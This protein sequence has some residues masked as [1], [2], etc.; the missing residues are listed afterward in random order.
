MRLNE[1]DEH[2]LHTSMQGSSSRNVAKATESALPNR[3]RDRAKWRRFVN[4]SFF[5][6]FENVFVWERLKLIFYW[7]RLSV[8]R[9]AD[10]NSA[11]YRLGSAQ[12]SGI[13][14]KW[15]LAVTFCQK[16]WQAPQM[17]S[18]KSEVPPPALLRLE[19]P[20]PYELKKNL[21]YILLK[22][23]IRIRMLPISIAVCSSLRTTNFWVLTQT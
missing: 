4:A 12:N 8:I 16:V 18:F 3:F 22:T 17:L 19:E 14:E 6:L 9:K 20:A 13:L 11:R 2:T 10:S 15:F 7:I 23:S 5:G 1:R 21:N